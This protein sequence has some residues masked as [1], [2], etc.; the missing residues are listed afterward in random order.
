M[1]EDATYGEWFLKPSASL[2]FLRMDRKFIKGR[3][4]PGPENVSDAYRDAV[5]GGQC[6]S[7][8][9]PQCLENIIKYFLAV[10]ILDLVSDYDIHG[11]PVVS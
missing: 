9:N 10:Q 7:I 4:N 2:H 1:V 11:F 8:S 5:R 3:R 6:C